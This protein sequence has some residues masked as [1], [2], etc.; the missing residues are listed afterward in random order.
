MKTQFQSPAFITSATIV[1]IG[2]VLLVIKS[3]SLWGALFLIPFSLGPVLINMVFAL[4][5]NSK[6]SQITLS[7]GSVIYAIWF[8]LVYLSA[9]YWH[10]DA[11]SSIALLFIGIYSLPIMILIWIVAHTLNKKKD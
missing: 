2:F 11:Q 1:I 6:R 8:G 4:A 7:I 10:I 9:F 3:S 5:L